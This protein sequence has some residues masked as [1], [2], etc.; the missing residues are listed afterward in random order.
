MKKWWLIFMPAAIAV[1]QTVDDVK[2]AFREGRIPDARRAAEACLANKPNDA[3]AH[4]WMAVVLQHREIRDLDEA[5]D[6]I[7]EAVERDP[8]NA[9]YQYMLG[10]IYGQT[11]QSA[12]VFKQA[13]LAPKIKRAFARAV[14][15]NPDHVE[16]RI[17]LAQYYLMAPGFMGGDD[18]EGFRQLDEAAKRNE[19]RGRMAKASMLER[20]NRLADAENEWKTLTGAYPN[21][22]LPHKNYG[23]FL[24]RRQ[25]AEE[26]LRPMARY[27]ALRPDTS[28]AFD[29]FGEVQLAAG[30]VDEAILTLRR[31]LAIESTLGSSWFLLGQAY[32]Q[33]KQTKDAIA[34]YENAM[35]HDRSEQR[36]KQASDRLRALR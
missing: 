33:K 26:A 10:G 34:A 28:D 21:D 22:W 27:A 36:K 24:L 13:L 7:E 11:A 35:L 5:T 17:A 16:A 2:V 3:D 25:R 8:N 20:K 15:L 1:S 30:R 31:G 4:Y 29:S 9:D 19:R 23:Y 6:H 12:G 18:D 32:E 14:E